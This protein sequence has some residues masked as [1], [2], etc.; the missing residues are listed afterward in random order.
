MCKHLLGTGHPM[1]S[2]KMLCRQ[3][4]IC[5]WVVLHYYH[6]RTAPVPVLV[7][8]QGPTG[9]GHPPAAQHHIPPGKHY[10]LWL[11]MLPHP[12][13]SNCRAASPKGI[14]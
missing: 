14:S 13:V 10:P 7:A 9:R 3:L 11:R 4:Q 6:M 5:A 8:G 1:L 12:A 2:W